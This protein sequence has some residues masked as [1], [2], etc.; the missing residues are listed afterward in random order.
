MSLSPLI[1]VTRPEPAASALVARLVSAGHS[2]LAL[3]LIRVGP[4]AEQEEARGRL[5]AALPADVLVFTSAEGVRQSV[6]LAGVEA[7]NAQ[8]IVVPGPGTAAVAATSGLKQ[9]CFPP[10]GG[11][12]EAMLTLPE[13]ESVKG[14]RVLIL[15]AADGRR[16]L[17]KVLGQRGAR[18]ERLVVYE[19]TPVE[20]DWQAL[21]AISR[22]GQVIVLVTSSEVL[23]R[24]GELI[25]P[26]QRMQDGWLTLLVASSR[27][28]GI[29]R[30]SG[31]VQVINAGAA[32]D[33]SMLEVLAGM[34]VIR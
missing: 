28:A 29:A 26:E 12:S 30:D 32:D 15:A 27:L 25:A 2:A 8:P 19:R 6:S 3:P 24:L 11:T 1:V 23:R 20:P 33:A 4:V 17:D 9:V 10:A 5:S 18:V 22:A 21:S 34:D 13:L 14:R 16:K 31:F 7:L